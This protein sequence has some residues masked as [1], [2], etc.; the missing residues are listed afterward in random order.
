M[1][2][3]S[4]VSACCWPAP[5]KIN[6]F[7]HVLGR[8]QD[9]YHDIQ[10]LF[11]LLD[12]GDEIHIRPA[13][14]PLISRL[15]VSYDV[16][17]SEDLVVRAAK[18]LQYETGCRRGAEIG[19]K[20]R[21]PPGSGMGG[22]SSDAATVLLVLNRLWDCGLGLDELASLGASLGADVPVFV[23]GRSAMAEGIGERLEPVSLGSPH[24]ILVFPAFSVS[25]HAVFSDPMLARDS[26]PVS[27]S[28]ALAGEGRNDCEVVV[29]QRFPVLARVLDALEKWGH[30]VMTGTGS[31]I[32]IP[33]RDEKSAI[34]AAK[35]MKTLY[36]VRAV[37]GVDQS[38]L[39][40]RL[41]G[42]WF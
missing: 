39:H 35:E 40:K 32:F 5:A 33:M 19:V 25:T 14:G 13:S 10:T 30:P 27:L 34:S 1:V 2:R 37:R 11:Q 4:E 20:K 22:G 16:S 8:R 9:G 42:C 24:Y 38:P 12:W 15:P 36:N 41:D 7:L 31:G 17:E 23:H 21:I 28:M 18:L 26:K 6:L 3:M 29:R